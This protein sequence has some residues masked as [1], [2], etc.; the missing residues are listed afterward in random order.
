MEEYDY[1]ILAYR[2]RALYSITLRI[3]RHD[4]ENRCR[5]GNI[6][7][8]PLSV[9]VIRL[10]AHESKT[11]GE[12]SGQMMLAPASLVPVVDI[13]VKKG[14]IRRDTDSKDR[15]RNPLTATTKGVELVSTFKTISSEDILVKNLEKLGINKAKKLVAISDEL[16]SLM[17]GSTEVCKSIR[18]MAE[19]DIPAKKY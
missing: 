10:L 7:V 9:A 1:K 18:N 8:S 2:L 5:R 12:L 19:R 13:L 16:L 3:N 11:I 17:A 15:R 14:L 4:L 6:T